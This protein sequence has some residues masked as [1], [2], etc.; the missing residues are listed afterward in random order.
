MKRIGLLALC[1]LFAF[2][3]C[4][5]KKVAEKEEIV[6]EHDFISEVVIPAASQAAKAKVETTSV[7]VV[8]M[9][10]PNGALWTENKE[11]VMEWGKYDIP[12]GVELSGVCDSDGNLIKKTA[13]RKSG[14]SIEERDFVKVHYDNKDLWVQEGMVTINAKAAIVAA[15]N[16]L[17]YNTPTITGMGSKVLPVGTIVAVSNDEVSDKN[18]VKI[19]SLLTT[20]YIRNKYIKADKIVTNDEDVQVLQLISMAKKSKNEA[21]RNELLE[22]AKALK[23]SDTVTKMLNDYIEEITPKEEEVE[24]VSQESVSEESSAESTSLTD[25]E[26]AEVTASIVETENANAETLDESSEQ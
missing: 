23:P 10:E 5:K 25:A 12:T 7:S 26:V 1:V 13:K 21:V 22:N 17:V 4:G 19:D 9:W 6:P 18:F 24:A 3:S 20:D 14:S 8:M 15:E 2:T 11:G 16:T